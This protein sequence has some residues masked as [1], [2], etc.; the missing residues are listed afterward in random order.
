[1]NNKGF[2]LVE[3]LAVLVL[4][5]TILLIFTPNISNIISDFRENKQTEMLEKSAIS[6][7]KE[8]VVDGLADTS[9]I[10]CYSSPP[11]TVFYII[12]Y[13]DNN[14]TNDLVSQ[15]YLDADNHY[16]DKKVK[17]TY[18]CNNKKFTNYE[19]SK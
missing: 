13:D 19:F 17:V 16:K 5:A 10:N 8:Y 7:A 9:Q 18:D 11:V 2:S 6:A 4:I 1:M 12:I 3:L 14:S 15:K